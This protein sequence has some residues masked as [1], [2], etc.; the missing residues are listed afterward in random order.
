MITAEAEKI[1]RDALERAYAKLKGEDIDRYLG[2]PRDV[3][4][5]STQG[6]KEDRNER[7]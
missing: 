7:A 5:M 2:Q 4:A 3:P 6:Y 1:R